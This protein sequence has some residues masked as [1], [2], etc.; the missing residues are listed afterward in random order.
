MARLLVVD[1]EENI[2]ELYKAELED[3][4]HVVT[5]AED[6]EDALK[7]LGEQAFDLVTLDMRMPKMDGVEL[8][9]KIRE[10]NLNIPIVVCSAYPGYK[11]DF[12]VWAAEAYIVKSSNL[13]ELK[14]TILQLLS[15]PKQ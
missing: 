8:L 6:G 4:G 1:D 5:T 14:E 9:G 15:H 11:Q 2:R 13:T 7:L 10:K 3:E 12:H